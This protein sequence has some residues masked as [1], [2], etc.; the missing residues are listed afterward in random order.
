MSDVVSISEAPDRA[1]Q[2][3]WERVSEAAQRVSST[4]DNIPWLT[5][6]GERTRAEL[7]QAGDL[8]K[9]AASILSRTAGREE[10]RYLR[11]E[12]NARAVFVDKSKSQS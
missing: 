12:R 2:K 5:V 3:L 11:L 1:A 7:A 8:L 10:L 9:Q 6:R 4:M